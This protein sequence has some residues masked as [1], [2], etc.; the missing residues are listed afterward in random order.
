[1]ADLKIT[2]LTS[3]GAIAGGDIIPI[4]RGGLNYQ[5]SAAISTFGA[6]LNIVADASAARN[7]L[8]VPGSVTT[9]VSGAAAI[10]NMVSLTSANYA[11]ITPVSANLYFITDAN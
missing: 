10:I 7:S 11:S 3:G 9:G 2:Q 4:V 8:F 5:V 1:M 6:T